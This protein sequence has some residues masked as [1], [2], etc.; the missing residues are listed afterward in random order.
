[1]AFFRWLGA[2]GGKSPLG[3]HDREFCPDWQGRKA[4]REYGARTRGASKSSG[5]LMLLKI[6]LREGA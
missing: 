2:G 3:N 6:K 5:A 4:R 1:M